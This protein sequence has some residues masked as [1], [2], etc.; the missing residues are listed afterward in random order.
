MLHFT[1]QCQHHPALKVDM[2]LDFCVGLRLSPT[3]PGGYSVQQNAIEKC[4]LWGMTH[5]E[6][7]SNKEPFLL[8]L[9]LGEGGFQGCIQTAVLK[10]TGEN[11]Y[12]LPLDFFFFGVDFN[13]TQTWGPIN[14]HMDY[15]PCYTSNL[16]TKNS[17]CHHS[18]STVFL[19]LIM[20]F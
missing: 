18:G 7:V 3:K 13:F 15:I 16:K 5:E 17:P 14:G 12:L 2:T 8:M 6:I 9:S 19:I 1:L 20:F 10:F 11:G 4:L